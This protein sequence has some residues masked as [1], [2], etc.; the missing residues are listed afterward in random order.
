MKCG[1]PNIDLICRMIEPICERI[2]LNLVSDLKFSG[3]RINILSDWM[4]HNGDIHAS[5]SVRCIKKIN[6]SKQI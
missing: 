2:W 4:I 1:P 6:I 3:F 5:Y